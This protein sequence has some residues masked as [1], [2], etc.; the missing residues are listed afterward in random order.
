MESAK[1]RCTW[2]SSVVAVS[3]CVGM[4]AS[5]SAHAATDRKI[6]SSAFC[7]GMTDAGRA[8]LQYNG[9]SLRAGSSDVTVVCPILRDNTVGGLREFRITF[10][11]SSASDRRQATV[12]F[13]SCNGDFGGGCRSK[14]KT[15]TSSNTDFTS[16]AP[17]RSELESL[18]H[19][20][21]HYYYFRTV[22]PSGWSIVFIRYTEE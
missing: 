22:L 12:Q 4:A 7:Q 5:S 14:P 2:I 9:S 8:L 17:T 16:A 3:F 1:M 15:T 18:P 6:M 13:F 11:K 21:K 10:K 19:G 20:D